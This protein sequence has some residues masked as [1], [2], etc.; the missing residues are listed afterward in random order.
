MNKAVKEIDVEGH[1]TLSVIENADRFNRWMY[2]IISAN[3]SGK[4]LEIGSGIGN[5]SQYFIQDG[6]DI[7]LSDLRDNYCDILKKKF[8][9]PVV[10][11]DLVHPDFDTEYA[12]IIGTFDTVFALNVV[13][14][15][16][17]DSKAIANCKKLL[18]SN[19]TIVI[20][21]PAYQALFNT[22]DVELE[23][24]RRY[25]AKSLKVIIEENKFKVK[26][27]FYFNL[28]GIL[29][30]FLSGRILKKKTIP[31]GQ[32]GIFNKLVPVFKL[33]DYLTFKKF[34]LSVIC[35]AEK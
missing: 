10:K 27:L 24:F 28:I 15:I 25:T 23:H 26:K 31:E 3:C 1:T 2:N 21:V 17:D 33:A 30:W 6:K 19:G 32:M 14:H 5:I 12:S 20:L 9:N 18:K 34:G 7:V 13:E 16:E 8:N 4:I 35:V 11:L 29:G 22:F